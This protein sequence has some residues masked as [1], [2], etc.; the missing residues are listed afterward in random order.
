MKR[1][2]NVGKLILVIGAAL[3]VLGLLF[4]ILYLAFGKEEQV[5]SYARMSIESGY[6]YDVS[7]NYLTYMTDDSLE[8][9]NLKSDAMISISLNAENIGFSV[10]STM[11]AF[12]ADSQFQIRGMKEPLNFTGTVRSLAAGNKYCAVL[13]KRNGNGLDTIL[14][15][16][17]SGEEMFSPI[18]FSDN[19]VVSFGFDTADGR[20]T[21]W[22]ICVNIESATPATTVR[23]YDFNNNGSMSYYPV[24][25]DQFIE[26]LAFSDDSVF[27]IGT[28]EIVRYARTGS[29]E[30]YRVPIYGKKVID[31]RVGD[32]YVYFLLQPRDEENARHVLYVMALAESDS[33]NE[34]AMTLSCGEDIISCFLQSG[35]IRVITPTRYLSYSYSGKLSRDVPLENR[36]DTAV[37]LDASRFLLVSGDDCYFVTILV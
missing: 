26:Q 19:K 7:D 11:T 31:Y 22:V 37:E 33:A 4:Y 20:E 8:Q 34:T 23:L 1:K 24:F 35:G 13:M 14:L 28:Q 12:F 2:L 30:Q 16:N 32:E 9:V 21:L 36:A 18:D 27:I 25:Y 10:S 5:L 17:A 15:Y 29:R 3:A 6:E